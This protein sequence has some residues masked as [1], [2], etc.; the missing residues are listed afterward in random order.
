MVRRNAIVGAGRGLHGRMG[1]KRRAVETLLRDAEWSKWS[2]RRI[3]TACR[4]G[5]RLVGNLRNELET[6][7]VADAYF[8]VRMGGTTEDFLGLR[9]V[10]Q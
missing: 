3:A 9:A 6:F 8:N 10:P 7:E 1:D 5:N 2:D 4:V